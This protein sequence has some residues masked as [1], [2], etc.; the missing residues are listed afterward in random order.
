MQYS[1]T[2][3]QVSEFHKNVG[4]MTER[5]HRLDFRP[6]HEKKR[7]DSFTVRLNAREREKVNEMKKLLDIKGDSTAIK[8]FSLIGLNVL[9]RVFS[10]PFLKYLFKKERK[11]LSDWEAFD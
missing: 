2:M 9:H 3:S 10:A 7:V 1:G 6:M 4:I 8:E 11:R 5:D